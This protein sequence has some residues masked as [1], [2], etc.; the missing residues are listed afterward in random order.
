LR[1]T[2]AGEEDRADHRPACI[3]AFQ[4]RPIRTAE[5]RWETPIL[6]RITGEQVL[7][8]MRERRSGTPPNRRTSRHA[9]T[10]TVLHRARR[11]LG[12]R[13]SGSPPATSRTVLRL[14]LA[15][16]C[17]LRRAPSEQRDGRQARGAEITKERRRHD[18]GL[19]RREC[20]ILSLESG[21]YCEEERQNAVMPNRTGQRRFQ[22]PAL[23]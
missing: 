8:D 12:G 3:P 21:W 11:R 2:P 15:I 1:P 22:H 13:R 16:T 5:W 6:L 14:Y 9:G 7:R 4:L 17:R 10:A 20:T 18:R 23:Q 19:E